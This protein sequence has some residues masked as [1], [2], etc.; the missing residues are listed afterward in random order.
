MQDTKWK[1]YPETVIGVMWLAG[2]GC[3]CIMKNEGAVAI[4][5]MINT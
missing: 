4:V 1:I 5:N 2:E 3:L